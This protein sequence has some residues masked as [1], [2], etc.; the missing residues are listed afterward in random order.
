MRHVESQQRNENCW[1]VPN[2]NSRAEKKNFRNKYNWLRL[3]ADLKRPQKGSTNLKNKSTEIIQ[4]K[5]I[6]KKDWKKV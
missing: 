1:K 3:R 6:G 5:K 4:S 2:G